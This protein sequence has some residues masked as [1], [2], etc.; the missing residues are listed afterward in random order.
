[1]KQAI[2]KQLRLVIIDDDASI[3]QM[4]RQLVEALDTEVVG[5][6][7]DGLS[8]IDI[9]E[10]LQP[11]LLLLDVSMPG[12]DGFAVA[13]QLHARLPK[14]PIIVS[15]HA[16]RAYAEEA[17]RCGAI[18]YVVKQAAVSEMHDAVRTA[19]AGRLFRSRLVTGQAFS[20]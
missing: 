19:M 20:A 1:M 11:D 16:Y 6:A 10:R 3:R 2:S 13:R 18:G 4:L 7:E 5:E 15:Q 14:L 9:V 8:G 12:L 17:F